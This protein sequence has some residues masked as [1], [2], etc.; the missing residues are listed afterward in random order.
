MKSQ[1][2]ALIHDVRF[3]VVGLVL[4]SVIYSTDKGCEVK[5][6]S[7]HSTPLVTH[8]ISEDLYLQEHTKN[9]QDLPHQEPLMNCE[10]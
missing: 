3:S 1:S 9:Q 4:L 6:T 2:T 8:L 7:H 5:Q 10:Q